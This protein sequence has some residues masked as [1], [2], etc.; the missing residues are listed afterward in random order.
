MELLV[1]LL[2]LFELLGLQGVDFVLKVFQGLHGLLNFT[3][4]FGVKVLVTGFFLRGILDPFLLPGLLDGSELFSISAFGLWRF[5]IRFTTHLSLAFLHLLH[6]FLINLKPNLLL[7]LNPTHTLLTLTPLLLLR[8]LLLLYR[9]FHKHLEILRELLILLKH[10]RPRIRVHQNLVILHLA[11]LSLFIDVFLN[12][13]Y[14]LQDFLFLLFRKL[15]LE[16]FL[17]FVAHFPIK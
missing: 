14:G 8:P 17:G 9:L 16:V 15:L 2:L 1:L 12:L 6:P 11:L 13:K 4:L 3:M 7:T 5:G 10:N